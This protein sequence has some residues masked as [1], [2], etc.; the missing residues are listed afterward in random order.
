LVSDLKNLPIHC[1]ENNAQRPI[2]KLVDKTLAITKDA[3]YLDNTAKQEKV[4]EYEKQI[5][6]L[7]YDLY[8]LTEEEIRIVEGETK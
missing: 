2:V 4:R 5:D 3:D 8:G 7:V 1:V 6:R